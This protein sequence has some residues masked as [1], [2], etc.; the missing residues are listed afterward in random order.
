MRPEFQSQL[1]E[2]IQGVP[3]AR[4]DAPRVKLESRIREKLGALQSD[5][6]ARGVESQD[7]DKGSHFIRDYLGGRI[8]VKDPS[9]LDMIGR[10]I[11]ERYELVGEVKD[12][13]RYPNP[14]TGYTAI[15]YQIRLHNGM[16]AELQVV[17]EVFKKAAEAQRE[18]FEKWRKFEGMGVPEQR[19]EEFES[20][21][22]RGR[23]YFEQA[24]QKWISLG[25]EDVRK[26]RP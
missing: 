11:A 18:I 3:G 23:L 8:V 22:D 4:L 12:F 14:K 15:H 2:T 6:K 13:M 5:M 21:Q 9:G 1:K 26:N 16:T 7:A 19:W 25:G 20:D 17:P 24:W 10:R